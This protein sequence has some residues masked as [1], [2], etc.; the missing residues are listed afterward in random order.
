[1]FENESQL[2]EIPKSML[3]GCTKLKTIALPKSI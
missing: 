1:M 2:K 3:E